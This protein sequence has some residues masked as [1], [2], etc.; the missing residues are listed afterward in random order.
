MAMIGNKKGFRNSSVILIVLVG[1][2]MISAGSAMFI[3]NQ[4][5]R[6]WTPNILDLKLVAVPWPISTTVVETIT[7]NENADLTSVVKPVKLNFFFCTVT[8]WLALASELF[9]HAIFF[10][11]L[12]AGNQKYHF[13]A[14]LLDI[15]LSKQLNRLNDCNCLPFFCLHWVWPQQSFMIFNTFIL[16]IHQ[17]HLSCLFSAEQRSIKVQRC[18]RLPDELDEPNDIHSFSTQQ[19]KQVPNH[20][21]NSNLPIVSSVLVSTFPTIETT[22][23]KILNNL[24]QFWHIDCHSKSPKPTARGWQSSK[25]IIRLISFASESFLLICSLCVQ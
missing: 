17:F 22:F 3:L 20:W 12:S 9:E 19:L 16:L 8:M 1:L 4:T 14:Q 6:K 11:W 7:K 21:T 15:S 10:L 2:K 23:L 13:F 24:T 18:C 25:T 5:L